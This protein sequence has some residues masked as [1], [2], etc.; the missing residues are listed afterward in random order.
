MSF[1]AYF[2]ALRFYGQLDQMVMDQSYYQDS[3]DGWIIFINW[4][5]F[6]FAHENYM[7]R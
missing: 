2:R 3:N 5:S 1:D 4:G 6:T 7:K